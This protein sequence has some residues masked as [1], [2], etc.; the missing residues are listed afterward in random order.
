MKPVPVGLPGEV[1]VGGAGVSLG[2]LNEGGEKFIPDPFA[3]PP[4]VAYR[5]GD[6]GVLRENGALTILGRIAGDAQVK[7]RGIRI[8][9]ED[10][11][12]T[13]LRAANGAISHVAVTLGGDPAILVAHAVLTSVVKADDRRDFLEELASNLPLPQYM[14]PAAIIPLKEC[15]KMRMEKSTGLRWPS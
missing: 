2:Y 15:H 4:A 7:L 8:E 12:S 3:E 6:K 9:M 13:I 5:T 11:E 10:I 1:V 14:R